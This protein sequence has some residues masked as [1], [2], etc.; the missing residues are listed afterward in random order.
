MTD[1][2]GALERVT[3]LFAGGYTTESEFAS[4]KAG[5]L[6]APPVSNTEMDLEGWDAIEQF[7]FKR[8]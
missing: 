5:I 8:S 2:A 6:S 3:S 7:P 1:L 4:A